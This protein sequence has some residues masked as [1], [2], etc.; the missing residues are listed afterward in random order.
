ML[1]LLLIILTFVAAIAHAEVYTWI[2][3]HGVRV[4]GD[5]PPKHAIKADLPKIQSLPDVK[6]PKDSKTET[7][8]IAKDEF[9]GYVKFEI[10]TPTEDQTIHFEETGNVNVQFQIQPALQ[11]GHEV[12]LTV[13]GKPID[14]A[15]ALQFQ[16]KGLSRGS[17]LLQGKVK[18]QG[19][20]LIS[21][22]K[23]RIHV[24][25]P[26]ILNRPRTQ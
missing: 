8:P 11:I 14:T 23:R 22:P 24:Q 4:Y 18:H 21:T 10:L 16:I 25:R 7:D 2:N 6:P 3:E 19:R 20:M 15:A 1:R 26:S 9:A 13:N 5:K 17:Y 12:S